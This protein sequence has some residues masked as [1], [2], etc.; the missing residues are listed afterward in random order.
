MNEMITITKDE[1]DAL[2]EAK[3][4]LED[5][6]TIEEFKA[7]PCEGLPSD[8]VRR[9]INGESE[10]KLWREHRGL[11]QYQ[12]SYKSGVNR[13]QIIDIEKGKSN[14]SIATMKKLAEALNV[15]LDDIC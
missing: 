11:S 9:M 13:V 14:G 12:L 3:E 2:I 1:Y 5:L 8:L 15:T 6:K 10:L 4:D 7:N